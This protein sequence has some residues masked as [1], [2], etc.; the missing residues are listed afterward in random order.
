VLPG[1]L[2]KYVASADA[3]LRARQR[4]SLYARAVKA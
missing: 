2:G 3:L 4:K 1:G